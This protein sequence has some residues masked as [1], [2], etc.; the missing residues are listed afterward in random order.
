MSKSTLVLS[1]AVLGSLLF[2][3]CSMVAKKYTKISQPNNNEPIVKIIADVD[4]TSLG[5]I[6]IGN[7]ERKNYLYAF[8]AAAQT[9]MDN[10]YKYFTIVSPSAI[11][12]QYE[13]RKVKNLK[14]AY[15][16]C[17]SGNGSFAIIS[18]NLFSDIKP[19]NCDSISIEGTREATL[20]GGSVIHAPIFFT[21]KMSNE[22][23]SEYASFNAQQVLNSEQLEGLDRDYFKNHKR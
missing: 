20:T 19:N 13:N 16:A 4:S 14:E 2:S 7:V 5:F 10:H 3:G 15:D 17:D 23:L 1:V 6:N 12:K 8:G 22:R 21:I 18:E 11:I 9:T